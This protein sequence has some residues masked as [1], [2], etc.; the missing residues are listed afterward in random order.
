MREVYPATVARLVD[1]FRR[2]AVCDREYSRVDLAAPYG[3]ETY[4][5]SIAD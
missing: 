5:G 2:M 1:L 4:T 3:E